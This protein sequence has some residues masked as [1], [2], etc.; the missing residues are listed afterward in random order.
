MTTS[1]PDQNWS[2]GL[3]TDKEYIEELGLNPALEGRP[4]IND[5]I[6]KAVMDS[7]VRDY[8]QNNNMSETRARKIAEREIR[9]QK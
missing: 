3:F 7:M 8:V 1:S 5:A 2:N 9:K 4:E 6:K